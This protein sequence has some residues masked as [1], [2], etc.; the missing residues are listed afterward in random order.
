[1][2][3]SVRPLAAAL[4]VLALAAVPVL[5]A[6]PAG[7]AAPPPATYD[8]LGDSY[9]SG[10]GVLPY[11]TQRFPW[12]TRS[13]ERSTQA[14]ARLIDGRKKIE[15]DDFA[16]CGGAKSADI[17]NQVAVLDADTDL[18]SVSVGGNDIFWSE[19]VTTCIVAPQPV[20]EGALARSVNA[21]RTVLPGLLDTAYTSIRAAA[22]DA[23]VVVTGY[24]RLFSPE[25]GDYVTPVGTLTTAEQ[26]LMN[27]GADLLNATIAGVAAKRGFE[28]VDVTK[29]FDGHGVNAPDAWIGGLASPAPFHPNLAGYTD[30]AAAIT[31]AVNPN[32]LR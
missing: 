32:E 5:V 16:A 24:A 22:P 27:D 19:A 10:A 8:A 6:G 13:C 21:V 23:H 18:V 17:A 31:A 15:L 2:R 4:A 7:S 1:M 28:F 30:Y 9:A 14:P 29:R 12:E 26:Q 25:Y 11:S 20:C 3:L